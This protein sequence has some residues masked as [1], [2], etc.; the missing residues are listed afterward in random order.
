MPKTY[1]Q[2]IYRWLLVCCFMVL[3][4]VAIGG[5][6]RLTGS[7]L[8]MTNWEPI[9]GIFPPLTEQEWQQEFASYQNSPEFKLINHD[10]DLD[11]FKGIFWLEFIHR[12]AGRLVGVIFFLPWLY[13]TATKKIKTSFSLR[14]LGIFALGGLQGLVGWYMVKSGLNEVPNVSHYWLA[15]HLIFACLLFAALLWSALSVKY[16]GKRLLAAQP[17]AIIAVRAMAALVLVQIMFGGWVA[18]LDA[19]LVYNTFPDMNGYFVPSDAFEGTLTANHAFVQFIHRITAFAV[20]AL[21]WYLYASIG[22][23]ETKV[24]GLAV[25]VQFAL[26]VATLL[27]Q[28]PIGLAS[29]HQ[30]MAVIIFAIV[31][32]MNYKVVKSAGSH[33]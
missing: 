22:S 15:G 9:S 23:G 1:N 26:G 13:F 27:Y 32:D 17:N 4:M 18:G 6:T 11:G 5:L 33:S 8:S 16:C 31:V 2:A 25:L 28:V 7:G 21:A 12:L 3:L 29:L 14:L 19:G 10:M 24:L 30:V 20:V